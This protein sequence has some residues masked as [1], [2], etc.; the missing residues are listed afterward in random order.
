MPQ[1]V[2]ELID[3]IKAE[4]I[5]AAEKKSQ[6]IES[7]AKHK[8][9][10]MMQD[11]HKQAERILAEAKAEIK[12]NQ[13]ASQIAIQQASRNVLLSLRK[14]IEHLLK[15]I[16]SARVG[17]SLTPQQLG[18]LIDTAVQNFMAKNTAGGDVRILLNEQD[19]SQLKDGFLNDLQK[20]LKGRVEFR[21][22]DEMGKGFVVS[23]DAG[24]SSFDFTENGLAEYLSG[25]LNEELG[26]IVKSAA[27]P[28]GAALQMSGK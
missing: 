9:Q 4:G 25:F 11:A 28:A 18:K 22:S 27:L 14:E 21:S 6:E 20:K 26:K 15:K 13:E 12:K 7:Q 2:Q 3:K 17:E 1:H 5:Q 19:L 24:K 10:Q 8:S 16:V 23:F